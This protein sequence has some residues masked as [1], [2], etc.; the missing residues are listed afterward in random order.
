MNSNLG[1][2]CHAKSPTVLLW[3]G[4]SPAFSEVNKRLSAQVSNCSLKLK[5]GVGQPDDPFSLWKM[6]VPTLNKDK[7]FTFGHCILAQTHNRTAR[8]QGEERVFIC[9]AAG[10]SPENKEPVIAGVNPVSAGP[11]RYPSHSRILAPFLTLLLT[12][13]HVTI[14]KP[15]HT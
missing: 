7:Q 1:S 4:K 11:A 2:C 13:F 6:V 12:R 14:I 9:A 5:A 8:R 10:Q 3:H 15:L